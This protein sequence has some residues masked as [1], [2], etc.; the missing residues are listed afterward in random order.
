MPKVRIKVD[1]GPSPEKRT[2][3]LKILCTK[4]IKIVKL[5]PTYDGYVA[6]TDTDRCTNNVF[7]EDTRN[8]LTLPMQASPQFCHQKKELK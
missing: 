1:R 2:E 8:T 5:L 4:D 6:I 7:E 3:L